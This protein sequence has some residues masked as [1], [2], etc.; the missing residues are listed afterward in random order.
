GGVGR[1]DRGKVPGGSRD[2]AKKPRTARDVVSDLHA[3]LVAARLPRPYVLVGHSDGGLFVRLY[4]STYPGQ[5]RGLVLV[6]AVG[7]SDDA[8]RNAFLKRLLPAA[9]WKAYARALRQQ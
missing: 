1:W 6:D 5:V 2:P 7:E 8:R 3:L 9:Q 4:A